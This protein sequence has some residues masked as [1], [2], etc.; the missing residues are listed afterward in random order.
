MTFQKVT[1]IGNLGR[2]PEMRYTP[3]G[4]AVTSFSIATNRTY[5]ASNG[6]KVKETTWFR[7]S[8]WGKL[9]ETCNQYLKQGKQVLVEGRLTGDKETGNPRIW[10]AQDGTPRASFEVTAETVRFLGAREDGGGSGSGGAMQEHGA[11]DF[12]EEDEIP[13]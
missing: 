1:L 13:F 3:N 6:E 11:P 12:A 5:T 9:A 4:Q 7:I 10:T 2:D 8:A